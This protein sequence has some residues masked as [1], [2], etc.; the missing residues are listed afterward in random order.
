MWMPEAPIEYFF[1][2]LCEKI[3]VIVCIAPKRLLKSYVHFDSIP[4]LLHLLVHI[5]EIV[6]GTQAE[7]VSGEQLLGPLMDIIHVFRYLFIL[8]FRSI[9]IE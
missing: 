2:R 9:Y 6:G 3:F 8:T 1:L 7:S 5:W 4:I